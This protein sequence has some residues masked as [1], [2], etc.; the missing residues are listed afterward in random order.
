MVSY[1][2]VV[3]SDLVSEYQ[4]VGFTLNTAREVFKK[5]DSR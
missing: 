2:Q 3:S 4:R 1:E 5:R